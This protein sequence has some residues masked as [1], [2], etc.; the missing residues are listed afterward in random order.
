[1]DLRSAL[2]SL[3]LPVA[4][5]GA[6]LV[7]V[8]VGQILTMP[9]PPPES[10]G[11]VGG[12]AV[13]FLYFLAWVGFLVLSLGLAIPPGDGYGITFTRAQ[14]VLFLLAA[15][16]AL[17]SAVG[18]F[19]AFGLI[20]SN[21]SLMVSAWLAITGIALLA[22]ATGLGWRGVQAVQSWRR[23]GGRSSASES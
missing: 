1:M 4:G 20:Y 19:V 16:A 13:L 9:S 12:L 15:V 2:G 8:S 23:D 22:L 10:D 6:F 14:R 3:Q 5:T 7:V 11:F 18:P 17:V 21:P